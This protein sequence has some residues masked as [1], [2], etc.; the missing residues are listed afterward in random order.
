MTKSHDFMYVYPRFGVLNDNIGR[1]C[2]RA[3]EWV[4]VCWAG[5]R[6]GVCWAGGWFS[7]LG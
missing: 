5:G 3:G 7:D 1:A 6:A 2:V 4:A